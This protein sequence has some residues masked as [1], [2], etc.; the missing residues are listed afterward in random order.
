MGAR[1]SYFLSDAAEEED[2]ESED[3]GD[4]EA[5]GDPSAESASAESASA[6][7]VTID[8]VDADGDVIRTLRE[9]V[10][11]GL[12][13]IV[14][15]L[16]RA[17]ERPPSQEKPKKKDAPEPAGADVLPGTYTVRI[18]HGDA[19]DSTTVTVRPDPRV[20]VPMEALKARLETTERLMQAMGSATE[21]ADRLRD[22][23]M[24]TTQ[25][26]ALFE[27][28]DDDAATEATEMGASMRDSIDAL[29]EQVTGKDVQGIRRDPTTVMARIGMAQFYLGSST[30][31][32]TQNDLRAVARAETRIRAFVDDVNGFFGDEWPAYRDA[33]D[34]AEVTLF[35]EQPPVQI[36]ASE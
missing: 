32:P 30:G 18:H 8:I 19:T 14:W 5:E 1:L 35:E 10:K 29:M 25:I 22:A 2:A 31:A 12:N 9:D 28:R 15:D 17:G 27:G 36:G 16:R 23:K 3:A 11:P 24:R 13:R 6:K 4:D 33:V 20:D 21:A 34:A 26:D 7:K